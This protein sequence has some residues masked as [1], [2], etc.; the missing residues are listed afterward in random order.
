M[1][2]MRLLISLSLCTGASLAT[3]NICIINDIHF[4][5]SFNPTIA[6]LLLSD[7]IHAVSACSKC[8][9]ASVYPMQ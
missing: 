7:A 3:T 5:F 8:V 9:S 6:L 1:I 4:A 2:D